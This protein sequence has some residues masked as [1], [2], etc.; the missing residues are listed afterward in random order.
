MINTHLTPMFCIQ[1]NFS[2]KKHTM[3]MTQLTF[4][5]SI[6]FFTPKSYTISFNLLQVPCDE[7]ML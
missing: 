6:T 5:L 1:K 4:H 7:T 2:P 3:S